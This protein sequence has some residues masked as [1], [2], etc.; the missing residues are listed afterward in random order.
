MSD[1]WHAGYDAAARGVKWWNNPYPSGSVEAFQW[2]QGHTR[3]R[4]TH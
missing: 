2:D 4:M 1:I 3:W